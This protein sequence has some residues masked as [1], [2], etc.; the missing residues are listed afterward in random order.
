VLF[1]KRLPPVIPMIGKCF[2]YGYCTTGPLALPPSLKE[3]ALLPPDPSLSSPV[4]LAVGKHE[5]PDNNTA[6]KQSKYNREIPMADHR[7][8]R[9]LCPVQASIA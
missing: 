4:V 7:T 8:H 2:V 3:E 6:A 1:G 5:Q 9:L